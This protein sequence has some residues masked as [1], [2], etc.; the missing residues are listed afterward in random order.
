MSALG[1][2]GGV[3]VS[4]ILAVHDAGPAVRST[5]D[6]LE[7]TLSEEDELVVIDDGST[8][9]TSD[10]LRAWLEEHPGLGR[11]THL[12][13]LPENCGVAHA[14]NTGL[15]R[16]AGR[17]VWFVDWDDS[18]STHILDRLHDAAVGSGATVAICGAMHVDERGVPLRRLDY[19]AFRPRTLERPAIGL[20]VLEG[21]IQGYLWNKLFARPVLGEAPFP[22][23]RSQ[24]DFM[25]IAELLA[26][27]ER[28][29]VVPDVL[30]DHVRRPGSITNSTYASTAPFARSVKVADRIAVDLLS[31][32]LAAP[33]PARVK[34]SLLIFRYRAYHLTVANTAVRL[35][36]EPS[37]R[38]RM[39]AEATR[40]MR[41]AE[42]ARLL[43]PAPLLAF[44]CGVLLTTSEHYP[45]VYDSYVGMRRRLRRWRRPR[46]PVAR[47][48][49][50]W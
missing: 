23:E 39:L 9:G 37:Y 6:S 15:Q 27:Q 34:R 18:W 25:G 47:G 43:Q 5:L 11:R 42:V 21:H 7:R 38:R 19:R 33:S 46:H 36:T 35:S 3:R 2:P 49:T 4:V 14:R 31:H 1:E 8:D 28:A 44:R 16:A 41:W 45:A 50:S 29:Q 22:L 30:Y 32:P 17:W 12:V 13:V 26:R 48:S 20:A 10:R 24:S 40:G